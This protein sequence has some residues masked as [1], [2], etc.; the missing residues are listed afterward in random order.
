MLP[1]SR[2]PHDGIRKN[3]WRFLMQN[4]G[5]PAA[6]FPQRRQRKPC[7]HRHAA[8]IHIMK[9]RVR[10]GPDRHAALEIML[11]HHRNGVRNA[12]VHIHVTGAIER[13][14]HVDAFNIPLILGVGWPIGF[15][16]PQGEPCHTRGSARH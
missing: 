7:M 13:D 16:R 10:T 6:A 15:S 3:P 12:L 11:R 1:K 8:K 2:L 9:I 5:R 14:I 4:G